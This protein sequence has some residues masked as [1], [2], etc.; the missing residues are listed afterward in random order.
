MTAIDV[1]KSALEPLAYPLA[2]DYVTGEVTPPY[3]VLGGPATG[4]PEEEVLS[5]PAL[6]ESQD[7]RITAVAGTTDG[8][9]IMLRNVRDL[10]SPGLQW[11]TLAAGVDIRYLRSEVVDVDT[12]VT[13]TATNRHPAYGVDTYRLVDQTA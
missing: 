12:S 13:M 6:D 4:R 1:V 10:L 7:L 3:L 9:R 8:A 5:G 11:T 2:V